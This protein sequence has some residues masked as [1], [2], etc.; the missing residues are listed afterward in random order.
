MGGEIGTGEENRGTDRHFH[1][2]D[3]FLCRRG[4]LL[5]LRKDWSAGMILRDDRHGT[6]F[7]R[8]HGLQT[9]RC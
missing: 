8:I 7:R 4:R 1:N 3:G 2:E 6:I 5:R 9:K